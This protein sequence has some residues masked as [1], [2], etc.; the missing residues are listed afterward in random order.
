MK[1]SEKNIRRSKKLVFSSDA[2]HEEARDMVV[3]SEN[4]IEDTTM[5]ESENGR[6]QEAHYVGVPQNSDNLNL[7][8]NSE[9]TTNLASGMNVKNGE[10]RILIS[11]AA[12]DNFEVL[13]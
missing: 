5:V 11:Q 9:N 13:Q 7:N 12:H 3:V 1:K 8:P 2:R 6:L 10:I 4:E